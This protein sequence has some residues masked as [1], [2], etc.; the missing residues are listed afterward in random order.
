MTDGHCFI[1][2][3]TADALDFA[4][5]LADELEGGEDKYINVW[6]DKRDMRS[7]P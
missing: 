6:F 3:S 7:C 4:R 1:S 5:K 2:Y